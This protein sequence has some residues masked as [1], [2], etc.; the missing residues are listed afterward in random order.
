MKFISAIF[1]AMVFL[2][3]AACPGKSKAVNTDMVQ[4]ISI[5]PD[6][7]T[8]LSTGEKVKMIVKTK[9]SLDRGSGR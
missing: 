6:P 7:S 3:L 8:D 9:Y 1:L 4:I 2:S 5:S